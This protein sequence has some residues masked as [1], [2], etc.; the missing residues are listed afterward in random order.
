MEK[1]AR[2]IDDNP[3]KQQVGEPGYDIDFGNLHLRMTAAARRRD[4][5]LADPDQS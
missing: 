4:D 1:S 3:A 5:D 2:Q